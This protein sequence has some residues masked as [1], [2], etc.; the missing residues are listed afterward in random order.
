MRI[1]LEKKSVKRKNLKKGKA[2]K[3]EQIL[4]NIEYSLTNLSSS[5]VRSLSTSTFA[6]ILFKK[7]SL[8]TNPGFVLVIPYT[9]KE[10]WII[11][12]FSC[13]NTYLRWTQF[14][15]SCCRTELKTSVIVCL[16]PCSFHYF[17]D[18]IFA[19]F[20]WYR[21]DGFFLTA[22]WLPLDQL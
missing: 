3:K 1:K 6:I 14:T 19:A 9:S 13:K 4:T 2:N 8:Q 22:I 17:N 11:A 10:H 5:S 12:L 16:I 20:T 21:F 7:S 18:V 15:M